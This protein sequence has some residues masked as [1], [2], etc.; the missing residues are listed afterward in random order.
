MGTQ[1]VHGPV[2]HQFEADF[3]AL[4]R[5]RLRHQ[6]QQLHGRPAPGLLLSRHRP[7]RRGDRAGAD[8]RRH[9]PRGRVD[10][11]ARRCSSTASPRPATSTVDE[12]EAAITPRTRAICV[13]HFSASRATWTAIIAHRRAATGCSWSRTARSPL[14]ARF[15]GVHAG[16]FGDVGCFSFYPV[17]HITTGEGG[18][19]VSRDRESRRASRAG[20]KAFGVDRTHGRAQGPGHVRRRHARLQLPHERDP[21]GARRRADQDAWTILSPSAPGTAAALRAALAELR[22]SVACSTAGGGDREHSH[23]CLAA[24]LETTS[25]RSAGRRSSRTLNARGV[26]TSVYYPQ[27]VPRMSY[28]REKYGY[29]PARSP[30][31]RASAISRSRCRWARTCRRRRHALHRDALQAAIMEEFGDERSTLQG[32]RDRAHRRR[33]VHRPQPRARS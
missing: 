22:R 11:R 26:G 9:R 16:L 32:K 21:G 14:G 4:H 30:T 10:R 29:E 17:K 2:A 19:F 8:A 27:P 5:R 20:S 31:P 18:M 33:R 12:I 25:R 1:L 13:V 7:G 6:R 3:A 15:D 24:V 28:Y 23:Y